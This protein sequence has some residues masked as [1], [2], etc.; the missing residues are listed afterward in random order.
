VN[1]ERLLRIGALYHGALG[2]VFLALPGDV[3]RSLG[4]EEPRHWLLYYL[5]AAAPAVAGGLLEFA[6]RRPSLRPGIVVSVQAGNL[7]AMLLV[8]FFT[9]WA[10]LPLL[11]LGSGAAAGLWAWLLGGVYSP[12]PS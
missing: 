2:V 6:R 12:P 11:L 3:V 4:I 10:D 5:S 9:V 7:V 8:V 1:P